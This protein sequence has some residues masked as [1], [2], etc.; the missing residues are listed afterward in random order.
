[1]ILSRYIPSNSQEV[2]DPESS[3]VVYTYEGRNPCAIGYS[4]KR[5]RE[6][7]NYSFRSIESRDQAIK[8]H[9]DNV[10]DRERRAQER[11]RKKAKPHNIQVGDIFVYSWGYEQTNV[12]YF[13][14]VATTPKTVKVR[15]IAK[16]ITETTGWM[17][18]TCQ[19]RPGA[20]L[21]DAPVLVKHPREYDGAFYLTFEFGTGSPW[22]GKPVSWSSYH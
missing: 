16:E 9:F 13:E 5:K 22:N 7:W 11:K 3:A 20:F 18:G 14:V 6:D 19:P 8:N 15:E 4:G 12:D 10:R 2:T 21:D 17:C 1:M